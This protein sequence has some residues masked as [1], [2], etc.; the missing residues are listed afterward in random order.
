MSDARDFTIFI[1]HEFREA[2]GSNHHIKILI[3]SENIFNEIIRNESTTAK[4]FLIYVNVVRETFI[5][6]LIDEIIWI[7]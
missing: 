4:K 1:K 7:R 5:D 3:N 6:H 2:L